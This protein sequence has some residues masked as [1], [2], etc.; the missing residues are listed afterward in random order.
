MTIENNN[1]EP[2]M[3]IWVSR[4]FQC[5]PLGHNSVSKTKRNKLWANTFGSES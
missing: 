4:S 1:I 5:K 2:M 3:T